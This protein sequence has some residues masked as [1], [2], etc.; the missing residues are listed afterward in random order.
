MTC[1]DNEIA[2]QHEIDL[3]LKFLSYKMGILM[4]VLAGSDIIVR[5]KLRYIKVLYHWMNSIQ[6]YHIQSVHSTGHNIFMP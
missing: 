5:I 4:S 3:S 6:I 1:S 2:L